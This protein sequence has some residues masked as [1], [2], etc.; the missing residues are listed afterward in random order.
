MIAPI[1]FL[2]IAS[3]NG[4]G[5]F[6]IF[7]GDALLP[8]SSLAHFWDSPCAHRPMAHRLVGG[9][10]STLTACCSTVRLSLLHYE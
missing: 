2:L 9:P 1:G 8:Q 10:P 3:L 6:C 7:E 5:C 4:L